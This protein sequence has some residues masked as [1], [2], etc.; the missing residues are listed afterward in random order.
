M[1]I[2]L[3]WLRELVE[4]PANITIVE[5]AR[6]L[7]L[8]GLEVEAI[9][10]LS[11]L[12]KDIII[13]RINNISVLFKNE[14]INLYCIYDGKKNIEIVF[15]SNYLKIGDL[16]AFVG[17]NSILPNGVKIIEQKISGI[18]SKG[19]FIS[20]KDLGLSMKNKNILILN[21]NKIKPGEKLLK[22][23]NLN[24]VSMLLS[25][26]PNRSD[27]LSQIG[28]AREIGAIFKTNTKFDITKSFIKEAKNKRCW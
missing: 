24:D 25:I 5:I 23:L 2:S 20:E 22:V 6:K 14:N 18:L 17:L 19:V 10:N 7:T 27:A 11:I 13:V 15:K 28:I 26:T 9:D 1:R 4:F 8:A 16:V 12:L 21:N 3:N